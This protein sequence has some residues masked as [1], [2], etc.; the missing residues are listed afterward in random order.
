MYQW[1]C[2]KNYYCHGYN[3]TDCNSLTIHAWHL[4]F[5]FVVLQFNL[6]DQIFS[7][8]CFSFIFH[9]GFDL[10]K[11][12]GYFYS[13]KGK[14]VHSI[15]EWITHILCITTSLPTIY[16]LLFLTCYLHCNCWIH[17][18]NTSLY[19]NIQYTTPV[20]STVSCYRL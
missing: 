20:L 3:I 14:S 19:C 13:Y 5:V 18:W 12:I 1:N 15:N 8:S 16:Y 10:Y 11:G 4:L 7:G 17:W 6:C 2:I 9:E